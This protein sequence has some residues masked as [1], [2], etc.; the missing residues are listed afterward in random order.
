MNREDTSQSG[1]EALGKLLNLSEPQ[2]L[3][4]ENKGNLLQGFLR[5]IS[6][7]MFVKHICTEPGHQEITDGIQSQE[8]PA[9]FYL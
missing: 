1:Y 3:H 4:G 2:F 5:G 7:I 9:I 8:N 6:K